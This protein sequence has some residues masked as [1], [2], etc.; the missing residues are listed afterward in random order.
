MRGGNGDDEV[1]VGRTAGFASRRRSAQLVDEPVSAEC[2]GSPSTFA[3]LLGRLLAVTKNKKTGCDQDRDRQ[4]P[5]RRLESSTNSNAKAVR[6][7][8]RLPDPA[9][10]LYRRIG[11][12]DRGMKAEATV[13]TPRERVRVCAF[14][15]PMRKI[16]ETREFRLCDHHDVATRGYGRVR[17][18]HT[19]CQQG[20]AR[21]H[22]R[23]VL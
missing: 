7:E 5:P 17:F 10:S 14:R 4:S 6:C 9:K 18:K 20:P 8:L 11:H 15:Y 13:A 23:H 16:G 22:R 19:I 3:P 21:G 2:G 1:P 12:L